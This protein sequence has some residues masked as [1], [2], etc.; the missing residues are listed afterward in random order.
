MATHSSTFA[1]KIP[2]TE[3]PGRLQSMELQRVRHDCKTSLSLFR[4][5]LVF[6]FGMKWI[7]HLISV[8]LSIKLIDSYLL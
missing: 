8:T 3:Q 4:T 5:Y 1:W 6:T 7:G 2:W